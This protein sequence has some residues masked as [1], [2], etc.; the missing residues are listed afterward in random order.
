[1]SDELDLMRLR[2]GS[3]SSSWIQPGGVHRP[4]LDL[5]VDEV[6]NVTIWLARSR[7]W[8]VLLVGAFFGVQF[9]PRARRRRLP[10]SARCTLAEAALSMLAA[11]SPPIS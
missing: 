3:G 11:W 6:A 10:G 9:E 5:Q 2:H 4:D 1:M 8:S 7:A